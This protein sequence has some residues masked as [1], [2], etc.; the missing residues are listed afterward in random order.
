MIRKLYLFIMTLDIL[1]LDSSQRFPLQEEHQQFEEKKFSCLFKPENFQTNDQ[2][3]ILNSTCIEAYEIQAP[4]TV[5]RSMLLSFDYYDN[6][7]DLNFYK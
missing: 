5:S 6:H 7:V 3:Q 2:D 4:T 1:V